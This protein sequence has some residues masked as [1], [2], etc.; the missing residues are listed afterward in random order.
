MATAESRP[1]V[2]ATS[3]A[4]KWSLAVLVAINVLN[5][6]DRHVAAAVVEPIRKEFLLTDTQLGWINTAFTILYGV[7]GLPLGRLADRV[8]RK[9]LLAAGVGVWAMLTAST[10]WVFSYPFLV[11]TRLGVGVGEAAAAPTAT[12]WIGDLY[13]PERRARPLALFMLGVPVGGALSYFFSGAIAQRLGW[14]AAMLVAAAPALLLIPLLLLLKE[15]ERGHSETRV[16]AS[17]ATSIGQVLRI[18]TFWWIALSGALVNFN[19][20]GIALFFPALFGRIHHM[21]V[22]R[23]GT[24]MGVIYAVGGVLGGWIAGQLGDRMVQGGRGRMQIAAIAAL[25]A[26]PLS[27]FGIRQGYGALS[28][29]LPL[30]TLSYGLLNM[31]YGLVYAAIQDIVA[32]ALRGTTMAMYFLVMYLS[33]A[34]WGTVIIGK[35]SD[36]FALQA[37]HLAGLQKINEAARAIGLQQALLAIPV[38]SLLLALVLWAGSRTIGKDIERK[39]GSIGQETVA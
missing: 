27:Y 5:F 6:Y 33:G 3:R 13:P 14:R 11:F 28:L 16:H 24:T 26:A 25:L 32:P 19:L 1:T 4:T 31:Y 36:H 22:A 21:N 8:S 17:G 38:L 2:T 37:A 29:V 18:P 10:R 12:S 35:M 15:P 30:L 23:A 34:S 9:K 7:V 39:M 20:Y